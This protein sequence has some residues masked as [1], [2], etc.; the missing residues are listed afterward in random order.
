MSRIILFL[1]ATPVISSI[2]DNLP[3]FKSCL[4]NCDCDKIS[5]YLFWTCDENCNYY[6]QQYIT[7]LR[8][9]KGLK[10]VQFYGKW[11]FKRL[12]GAQ[13]F[14][15]T[16]FSFGNLLVN[17]NNF[18]K[19]YLQYKRND[20]EYKIL[21]QQ[22]LILLGISCI[23]WLF[24]ILFHY[25]D[26]SL[27]E[28][29]D[30]FGAFAIILSNLNAITVRVFK[31]DKQKIIIWQI[32]LI[33]LYLLHVVKLQ[34]KWDYSYNM[35]INIVV[36]ISA[37]ILWIY[38]SLKVYKEYKKNYIIYNNSIQLLPYE[39]KLLNKLNYLSISNKWITLIPILNNLIL[40]IGI[41]LETNDFPPIARYIDAHSLWHFI[42][43]F[44]NLIWYDWNIWDIE[45]LKLTNKL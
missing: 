7:N 8:V 20:N 14:F 32:L 25:K 17:Y 44:P 45:M 40:C 1:L 11:P 6:C 35:K 3:E 29:L 13:E 39:T 37:M 4:I 41:S 23:G 16:L 28:T 21:Y 43:I 31:F 24:S 9:E 5:E 2:G 42:T 30:Y 26:T 10:I 18:K 27:T 34:I 12:F 38:H 19:I 22:Y 36:G 15:A 33:L